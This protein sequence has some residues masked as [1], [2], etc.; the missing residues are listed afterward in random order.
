MTYLVRLLPRAKLQL[1][2]SALWWADKR[3][4]EQAVLWLD[5]F[6]AALQ[7]LANK[8]EDWPLAAECDA[9]PFQI[10]EMTFGLGRNKTHRAIFEIRRQE[11]IVFAIR[12][13]AQ[14]LLTPDDFKS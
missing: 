11:V 14:D 10:R 6:E 13:L 7:M 1:V 5:G 12:H 4:V 9:V 3:S 2:N 8:P